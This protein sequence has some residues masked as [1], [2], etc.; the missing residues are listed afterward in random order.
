MA[1]GD[2]VH[3]DMTAAEHIDG[4][5]RRQRIEKIPDGFSLNEGWDQWRRSVEQIFRKTPAQRRK[6]GDGRSTR[7]EEVLRHNVRAVPV[8]G[9]GQPAT[10][11]L[12]Q[13][14]NDSVKEASRGWD[15]PVKQFDEDFDLTPAGH[16]VIGGV[17]K[18]Q[19]EGPAKCSAG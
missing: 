4:D 3:S 15:L 5:R 16:T 19:R 11:A 7:D 1:E 13:Q 18:I 14:S 6:G 9:G 17:L 10:L 8:Y 12:R 2:E